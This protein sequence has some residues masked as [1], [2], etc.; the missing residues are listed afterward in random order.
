MHLTQKKMFSWYIQECSMVYRSS[1]KRNHWFCSNESN[2]K[3]LKGTQ[4]FQIS[5]TFQLSWSR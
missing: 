4:N 1:R 5:R 3:K 2:I